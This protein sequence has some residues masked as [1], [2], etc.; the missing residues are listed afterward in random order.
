[1][2]KGRLSG[3]VCCA[4]LALAQAAAASTPNPDVR[5]PFN[6][7]GFELKGTRGYTVWVGANSFSHTLSLVATKPAGSGI[8]GASYT[9]RGLLSDARLRARFGKRGFL[10]MRFHRTGTE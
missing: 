8:I 10:D 5:A 2:G 1:M 3:L 6:P 4:V 9:V 7:A